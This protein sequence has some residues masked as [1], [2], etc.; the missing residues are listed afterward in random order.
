MKL[1]NILLRVKRGVPQSSIQAPLL[2]SSF[3]NDIEQIIPNQNLFLFADDVNDYLRSWPWCW[4]HKPDVML[5]ILINNLAGCYYKIGVSI[6]LS[7]T[8]FNFN[9]K[10]WEIN[11]NISFFYTRFKS[12]FLV[13]VGFQLE[14]ER[15][16][17]HVKKLSFATYIIHKISGLCSENL[18]INCCCWFFY[19]CIIYSISLWVHW[20]N[21]SKEFLSFK[22]RQYLSKSFCRYIFIN[23]GFLTV[24]SVE[25]LRVW[26]AFIWCVE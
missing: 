26:N 2:L 19:S 1:K 15:H 24:P 10:L 14:L 7:K 23:V 18:P 17:D 11:Q 13:C 12:N 4:L 6:N 25:V 20:K 5:F 22:S 8:K 21:F 3:I 16:V 9:L